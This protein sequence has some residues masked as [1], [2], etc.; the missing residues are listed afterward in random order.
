MAITLE[1]FV[2]VTGAE[3]VAGNVIVGIMSTRKIVGSVAGGVFSLTDEGKEIA[4]QIEVGTY[5]EP[6][7]FEEVVEKPAKTAKPAKADK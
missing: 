2:E 1:K 4:D 3:E 6:E 5:G 7:V